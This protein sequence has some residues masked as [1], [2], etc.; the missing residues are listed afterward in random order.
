MVTDD[1]C[2]PTTQ[3]CLQKTERDINDSNEE[4]LFSCIYIVITNLN[5]ERLSLKLLLSVCAIG[6]LSISNVYQYIYV[7]CF[8]HFP[9]IRIYF[10]N[11]RVHFVTSKQ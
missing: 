11:F 9:S 1:R 10:T 7:V 8:R 2:P 4:L 5:R 6:D 3:K